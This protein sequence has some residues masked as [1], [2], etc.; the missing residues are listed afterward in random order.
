MTSASAKC[1]TRPY[2]TDGGADARRTLASGLAAREQLACDRIA[3]DSAEQQ[4]DRRPPSRRPIMPSS[5]LRTGRAA[6]SGAPRPD[7]SPSTARGQS[8]TR[9]SAINRES[10]CAE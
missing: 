9:D 4:A 2:H 5:A 6:A 1:A 8:H 7:D 3:D 10:P